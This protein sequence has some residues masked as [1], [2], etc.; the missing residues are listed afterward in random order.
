MW[1]DLPAGTTLTVVDLADP[2]AP[3]VVQRVELGRHLYAATVNARGDLLATSTSQAGGELVVARLGDDGLVADHVALATGVVGEVNDRERGINAVRFHPTDDV[4]AAN[5]DDRRL[6]FLR[7]DRG[8]GGEL[9][10]SAVGEPLEVARHWSVGNWHPGG[11]T[12]V[13]SDVNWGPGRLGAVLNGR[14]SLVSVR[15]DAAGGHAVVDRVRVGLSPE[16]FD[17]SPDGSLAVVA[18]MRRTYMPPRG[19]W[20]VPGKSRA[21]LS[22]VGVDGA[23]GALEMLHDDVGFVGALP[24][25]A[26][27]DADGTS[28]AVAVYHDRAEL[29]P[30]RGWVDFW[31]VRGGRR[32]AY[33]GRR[34][35]VT[36]GVHNLLLVEP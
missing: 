6:A 27:F 10:V 16:G 15:Y 32:L 13:L 5:V 35:A 31:E 4:L 30:R 28:V 18:N 21:S 12:F 14:G 20:F 7:V 33:T 24:E 25:D 9:G 26:V 17:L 2:D 3:R 22:L 1:A 36:R 23:T 29:H 11:S 19:F 8:P 34:V